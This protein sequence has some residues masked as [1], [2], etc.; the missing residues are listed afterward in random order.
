MWGRTDL[1]LRR[2]PSTRFLPMVLAV[3]VYFAALA[4]IGVI[5]TRDFVSLW[6]SRVDGVL[7]V[8]IPAVGNVSDKSS[9]ALMDERRELVMEELRVTPGIL[10]VVRLSEGQSRALLEP[11]IG[12]VVLDQM[13]LPVLIDVRISKTQP[14]DLNS[15]AIRLENVAAGTTIEDHGRWIEQSQDFVHT[16]LAT[17]LVILAIVLVT[18]VAAV[19]FV[20]R[21]G[22]VIHRNQ[23]EILHLI[24][25]P[26]GYI[27]RQF[28]AHVGRLCFWGG[29]FGVV[30]VGLTL[31]LLGVATNAGE[32]WAAW[33][34]KAP[35]LIS[36][37]WRAMLFVL[38][39]PFVLAVFS[40]LVARICV[41]LM[42]LSVE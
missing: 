3:L 9:T 5:E 8:Q 23:I 32:E 12:K 15:L 16:V 37:H 29:I 18:T 28:Q 33:L 42:L 30:L 2:D 14:V 10:R 20:I 7:T 22:L 1:A 6:Q 26:D 36:E 38:S 11:W 31:V 27:A 41:Q 21:T 4:G 17:S 40:T 34:F 19:V 35:E 25:A 39:L 13:A 24:G